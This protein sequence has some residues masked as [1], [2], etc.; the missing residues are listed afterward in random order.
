M[1]R[2]ASN[3]FVGLAT[4]TIFMVMA[5]VLTPISQAMSADTV[6]RGTVMFDGKPPELK[7]INIGNDKDCRKMHAQ[8]PI[9]NEEVLVGA[10]GGLQNVFVY[11]RS[12]VPDGDYPMPEEPAVLDQ[13]GCTFHPRMQ[14]VRVGQPLL[15][16]N[17]D[18]FTH[19]VRSFALAN[20]PFNFG[21]PA[22]TDPR[23]RIFTRKEREPVEV[24]CD[25]HKWMRA[26]L[27]VVDHP[28]H[29]VTD[30]DGKFEIKGLPPGEYR[31]N[32]WHES[33]GTER[34]QVEVSA[35]GAEG[36]TFTFAP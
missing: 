10:N 6:V 34:Q 3:R 2:R 23:E 24:Q 26:Y 7:I 4:V 25:Y 22:D 12:N 33:L 11:L 9:K 8:D 30:K 21:Q 15:V 14:V 16:K 17:S 35:D 32:A 18:P 20:R 27:L 1:R 31:L 5:L 13:Q 29:A 36:V 19:N 28:F